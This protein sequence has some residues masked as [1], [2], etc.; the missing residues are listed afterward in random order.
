MESAIDR[1]ARQLHESIRTG[2]R[3]TS[4]QGPFLLPVRYNPAECDCPEYEIYAYGRWVR[5]FVDSHGEARDALARLRDG[6][7]LATARL[8]GRISPELR[9]AESRV[10]YPVFLLD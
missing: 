5:V 4:R 1:T 9:T 3:T 6:E 7:I 8:R 10:R 2:V